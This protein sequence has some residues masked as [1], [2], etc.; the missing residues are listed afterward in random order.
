MR[1]ISITART[2]DF[3]IVP[4]EKCEVM[5]WS[6]VTPSGALRV[7]VDGGA[8]AHADEAVVADLD[9][10]VVRLKGDWAIFA[11]HRRTFATH[12]IAGIVDLEG[13]VAGVALTARG[14]HGDEALADDGDVERIAGALH[15]TLAH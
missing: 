10:V 15:R 6:G 11:E 2:F 4:C 14:L 13:A 8:C 9:V 1:V 3:S 7:G 12:Q 5:S